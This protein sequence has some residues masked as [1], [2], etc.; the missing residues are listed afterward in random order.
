MTTNG[1]SIIS[2]DKEYPPS[3]IVLKWNQ[4]DY[5]YLQ[6]LAAWQSTFP[7]VM[8]DHLDNGY[9]G[10]LCCESSEPIPSIT[11]NTWAATFN[12]L[13]I[14]PYNGLHS[15]VPQLEA[16]TI[17]YALSGSPGYIA[18]STTIY[19]WGSSFSPWGETALSS[20]TTIVNS[21]SNA[22]Y[23]ISFTP[24][25]SG[26]YRKSRFYWNTSNTPST[27]TFFMDVLSG[28][29]QDGPNTFTVW[30]NYAPYSALTPP[31][32]GTAFKGMFAGGLFQA[33]S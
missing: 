11:R 7:L 2:G 15:T 1:T 16:P 8:V 9:L 3:E 27:A 12:F 6:Q 21:T 24:D 19:L 29:P 26:F 10:V 5:S 4:I 32:Y 22:A 18:P 31:S 14:G 20:V 23:N 13:V 17:A 25:S 30:G 28:F 33:G